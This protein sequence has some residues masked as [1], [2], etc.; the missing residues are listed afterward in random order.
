MHGLATDAP[1]YAKSAPGFHATNLLIHSANTV[2]LFLL[3]AN[4]TGATWRSAVV[5]ALFGLHPLHVESV[6][7]VAERKDVLSTLF[8]ILATAAYVAYARRPALARYA[9]AVLLF[10]ASLASKPMLV[11]LPV[12]FLLLDFGPLRRRSEGVRR[13]FLEKVPL[14]VLV[15][16]SSAVTVFAQRQ[17]G[18]FRLMAYVGFGVRVANA[19]VAAI[20]YLLEM[21]WPTRL[22]IFYPHPGGD[23]QSW[24]VVASCAALAGITWF[25]IRRI[26]DLP[27]VAFGWFWYLVSILPVI[28]IVQVGAQAMADRYTYVPL[29]GPFVAIVWGAS[30]AASRLF[31]DG[32]RASNVLAG[33]AVVTLGALFL[34][35]RTQVACWKDSETLFRHAIAC[36]G[37]DNTIAQNNLGVALMQSGRTG[38]AIPHFESALRVQPGYLDARVNL[39]SAYL[40]QRK[41]PEAE[42]ELRQALRADPGRAEGHAALGVALALGGRYDEAVEHLRLAVESVPGNKEWRSNLDRAERL[43]RGD[44]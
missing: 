42:S 25:A 36:T 44:K 5:S 41:L 28:G 11:T 15:A 33:A 10:V 24:K 4:L 37:D 30:D 39:G 21:I 34:V 22:A 31:A 1:P 6:A 7:W 26:R 12:L 40:L 9:L 35:A 13:L 19:A 18:S 2:L 23:L 3:L 27:Y 38:E 17:G 29:I 32:R 20:A 16:A 43:R 14:L 8:G